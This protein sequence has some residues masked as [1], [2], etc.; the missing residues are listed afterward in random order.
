M[1]LTSKVQR[2]NCFKFESAANIVE[3]VFHLQ[4]IRMFLAIFSA[5]LLSAFLA[6]VGELGN[7]FS[8]IGDA[9]NDQRNRRVG[10]VDIEFAES[11][12]TENSV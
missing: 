5:M 11:I 7:V 6:A 3:S 2:Y 4:L 12:G 8:R 1:W 9:I 10:A